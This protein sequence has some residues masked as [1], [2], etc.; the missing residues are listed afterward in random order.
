MLCAPAVGDAAGWS[1]PLLLV[2]VPSGFEAQGPQLVRDSTGDAVAVWT[3]VEK[4][5]SGSRVE[6]STRLRGGAWSAPVTL[7][8]NAVSEPRLA[9]DSQGRTTVVWSQMSRD[10]RRRGRP[11]TARV[12]VKVRSYSPTGGWGAEAVLASTDERLEELDSEGGGTPT[13]QIAARGEE[14]VVAFALLERKAKPFEGREDVL[15]F[16]GL[17]ERWSSAV[18]VAH[19]IGDTEM[20]LGVDG[21]GERILAWSG[22]AAVRG[23]VETQIVALNGRTAGTAQT[24]SARS[25]AAE[26]LSLAVNARGD[27]VLTWSQELADGDGQG[28][29][30]ATTRPAGGRF[31]TKPVVLVHKADSAFTAINESGTATVQY[32]R[33]KQSGQEQVGAGL[34]AATHTALGSWS[35]PTLV[36]R[37]VDLLVLSSGPDGELLGLWE[38][39]VPGPLFE[40][41]PREIGVIDASIQ[42]VLGSWQTPQTISPAGTSDDEAALGVAANGQATAIWVLRPPPERSETIET[43]DYP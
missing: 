29:D 37:D 26:E 20:R 1:P 4:R 40:G 12:V 6:A 27:A 11:R 5:G 24:V 10:P 18:L 15:L 16:T 38:G 41:K 42:P 30:E 7:S 21:R 28:P 9:M 35:R 14:V 19:T 13:P 32:N 33:V 36:A 22:A 23:W 3:D 25:G 31:S 34:E 43:A 39:G 2:A 17:G 8:Y